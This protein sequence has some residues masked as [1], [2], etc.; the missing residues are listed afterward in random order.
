MHL[1][2][3]HF[4]LSSGDVPLLQRTRKKK[5]CGLL[6]Y[7]SQLQ[8]ERQKAPSEDMVSK[9]QGSGTRICSIT[10]GQVEHNDNCAVYRALKSLYL[11]NE[12]EVMTP[13]RDTM[14]FIYC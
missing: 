6:T 14:G 2:T 13:F 8:L 9:N 12:P 1:C 11:R 4:S 5:C 7:V 3:G 10:A